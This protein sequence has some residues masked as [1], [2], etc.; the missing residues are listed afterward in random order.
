MLLPGDQCAKMSGILSS[1]FGPLTSLIFCSVTTFLCGQSVA[2]AEGA[3]IG[4]NPRA[5]SP[6]RAQVG[7][8]EGSP[9]FIILK[10]VTAR[11]TEIHA[12][13]SLYCNDQVLNPGANISFDQ[14]RMTLSF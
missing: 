6:I 4:N 2:G 7:R 8:G 5:G 12:P 1:E 11:V 13:W 3:W 14:D 10:T 9:V